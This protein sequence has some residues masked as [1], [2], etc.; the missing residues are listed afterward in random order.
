M[1]N[2][3]L[4]IALSLWACNR[5]PTEIESNNSVPSGDNKK[6]AKY[7]QITQYGGHIPL[8]H[9]LSHSSGG[10]ICWGFAQGRAFG[11]SIGDA[12][13]NPATIGDQFNAISS[14]Y[15]NSEDISGQ[16]PAQYLP[17]IDVGEILEWTG[18]HA[19]YVISKSG[20][21]STSQVTVQHSNCA[22]LTPPMQW[23]THTLNL[24]IASATCGGQ[25]PTRIRTL[26]PIPA[27]TLS[28]PAN[29]ATLSTN[30]T[31]LSWTYS[32]WDTDKFHVQ[33]DNNSNFASPEVNN[34]NVSSSPYSITLTNGQYWWRVKQHADVNN[35]WGPWSSMQ[36][37]TLNGPAPAA[38][39]INGNTSNGHPRVY[40]SAVATATGY[41]VYRRFDTSSGT[42]YYINTTTTLD[43][44]DA[45]QNIYSGTGT[46]KYVYYKVSAY[47][48]IGNEGALSNYQMFTVTQ[49][50]E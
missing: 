33:V 28:S 48:S 45:G 46:K 27:P 24:V 38:P 8:T 34:S 36:S 22:G 29:G 1:M 42:Y 15:F 32:Y 17:K 44:V 2:F 14:T 21:S 35:S 4:C 47:N 31:Q 30:T 26:K 12:V 20:N 41:K 7:P 49:I 19:A 39:T 10:A 18:A 9:D 50:I 16:S 13:C 11:K 3:A 6:G 25:N 23:G 40:W 5:Q 37:F 43:Y